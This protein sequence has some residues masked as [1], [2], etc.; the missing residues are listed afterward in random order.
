[1]EIVFFGTPDYV[2]PVVKILHKTF[3]SKSGQSPIVAVVTQQPK[4]AGRKKILTYSPVDKWAHEKGVPIFYKS[5][6][7][8]ENKV[9]A[10][11]GILASFGE[12]LPKEIIN[13][14]PHGILNIHPSLLPKYRGASPVRGAIAAGETETGATIIKLDELID[15]GK[16]VSQF[17]QEIE[18]NDSSE[19]LRKKLFDQSAEVL[20]NLIRPYLEGKINL[21]EQNN[22]EATFATLVKKENAQI[23]PKFIKAA[24]K[25][26][27]VK[28]KWNISFLKKEKGES[29]KIIPSSSNIDSFIR[30]MHPWPTAWTEIKMAKDSK[31]T[32]RLKILKAHLKGEKL[33]LDEVQ[34]EGKNKVTWEQFK[35]GYPTAI[36]E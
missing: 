36:F 23:T 21:E 4:P 35:Q 9:K 24:L 15:H 22:K 30:A 19:T 2:L 14:F 16:I 12:I 17:K 29:F 28:D 32:K 10:D 25:G 7:L 5:Q 18:K 1:M 6:D 26:Q 33:V 8:I 3:K 20:A 27:E 31:T 11:L 13:Y 34:L